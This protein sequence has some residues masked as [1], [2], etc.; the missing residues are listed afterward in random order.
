MGEPIR[1]QRNGETL[2]V[3]G[4]SEA[5]VYLSDGWQG[6]GVSAVYLPPA[7]TGNEAVTIDATEAAQLLAAS[8]GIDLSTVTGSGKG[9]RITINDVKALVNGD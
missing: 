6:D 5:A 7:P 4:R 1:L 9:G 8:E 2:T 3:Y